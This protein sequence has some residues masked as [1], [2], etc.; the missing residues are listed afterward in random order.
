[1]Q[2]GYMIRA[3]QTALSKIYLA[4]HN[5]EEMIID[6]LPLKIKVKEPPDTIIRNGRLVNVFTNNII[7]G[8]A[9]TIKDRYITGIGKESLFTQGEGTDI[10]DAEGLYLCPGFIDSHTHLDFMLPFYALVPYALKGGTTTIV[11][12]CAMV[13]TSC[14]LEGLQSFIEST[15]GYPIHCFFLAPPL[16]PPF[17]SM[18]DARGLTFHQFARM[19]KR[20]DF[21]GIGEAYWTRIVEHDSLIFKRFAL[22]LSLRKTI[23]GHSAGARNDKLFQ[24]LLTGIT[25]CHESITMGEALEKLRFGI[26]VMIREGWIRRELDELYQLKDSGVDERRIILVS[27]VFDPVLLYSKGYMDVIVKKAIDYG[28]TPIQAIKM[29]TINPADY[30][31]LRHLGAIAPFRYAD[32]L[33]LK[34]ISTIAIQKVMVNGKMVWS[35]GGLTSSVAPFKY[36]P[37]M[38]KTIKMDH[39][40]EDDFR[41]KAHR[42]KRRVRVIVIVNETITCEKITTL[43]TSSGYTLGD[44]A[45]DII[46]VAVINRKSGKTISKGFIKGTGIRRGAVTTSVVWDTGNILVVGSTE[47]DMA[48]AVNRLIEIQGGYVVAKAGE[49]ICDFSM[50]AYGLIPTSSMEEIVRRFRNFEWAMKEIGSILTNPLLTLQTIPFT[51][52]PSLRITDKGIADIKAKHLVSLYVD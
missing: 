11:S 28:F 22:A 47:R 31:G 29:V 23:E 21:L 14:G 19:L 37:T 38:I 30:F 51:G 3:W 32:I 12:E 33:F 9:V 34:D 18:E 13:A 48:L 42:T 5:M 2:F 8:L 20:K 35:E 16:T 1:M 27:D 15:K 40:I 4:I 52:L 43:P 24:Y 41:I 50:P 44:I 46:Y 49:I 45:L 17:P 39:M 10:I 7:D 25:S 6:P 26:Y 36:P